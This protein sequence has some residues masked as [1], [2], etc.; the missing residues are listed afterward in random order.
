MAIEMNLWDTNWRELLAV[1]WIGWFR[2][3]SHGH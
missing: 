2:V 1:V 3:V